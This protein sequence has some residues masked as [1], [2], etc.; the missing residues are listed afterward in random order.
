VSTAASC[1]F[2]RMGKELRP[3]PSESLLLS[4]AA[5]TVSKNASPGSPPGNLKGEVSFVGDVTV[6]V[7]EAGPGDL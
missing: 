2:S 6:L 3:S 4:T 1:D 7:G 5:G